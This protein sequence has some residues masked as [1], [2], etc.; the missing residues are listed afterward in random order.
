VGIGLTARELVAEYLA[1]FSSGDP[2]MVAALVTDDF[3]NVHRSSLGESSSGRAE[4]LE[5]LPGFLAAFRDLRYEAEDVVVEGDRAAVDYRMTA[6][7]RGVNLDMRGAMH[8]T[9]ADGRIARRVDYWDSL[10][11]LR[12]VG[13]PSR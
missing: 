4:Y 12:Q 10:D 6:I 2:Q 5:R 13:D 8:F 3:E 11:Y 1:A 7:H 9:V